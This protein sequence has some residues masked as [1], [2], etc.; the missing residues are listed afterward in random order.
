MMSG[1]EIMFVPYYMEQV[2]PR[3]LD[4][5]IVCVWLV[6]VA[7]SDSSVIETK[8]RHQ[9]EQGRER[10]MHGCGGH[11]SRLCLSGT[12]GKSGRSNGK[13]LLCRTDNNYNGPSWEELTYI[14]YVR[15]ECHH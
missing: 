11:C 6:L 1:W 10:E 15:Y 14:Q 8:R 9:K 4:C 13:T 5:S 3:Q 2:Y 7:G 12:C